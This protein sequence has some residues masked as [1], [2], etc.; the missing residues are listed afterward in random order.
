[1]LNP[2]V[3]H[4][5]MLS[6]P[7]KLFSP[8]HFLIIFCLKIVVRSGSCLFCKPVAMKEPAT[9]YYLEKSPVIRPLFDQPYA[10]W[11]LL[12]YRSIFLRCTM[13]KVQTSNSFQLIPLGL[14]YINTH[15]FLPELHLKWD[16]VLYFTSFFSGHYSGYRGSKTADV[17]CNVRCMVT[18]TE[19]DFVKMLHSLIISCLFPFYI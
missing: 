15:F 19:S 13:N 8:W 9:Y 18:L 3:V 16:C 14:L 2:D 17:V 10:G 7:V 6:N 12:N 1:M 4:S 5:G 11:L